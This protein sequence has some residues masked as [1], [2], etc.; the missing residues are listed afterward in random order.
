MMTRSWRRNGLGWR[1]IIPNER[2]N[3]GQWEMSM[4][5]VSLSKVVWRWNHCHIHRQWPSWGLIVMHS[6]ESI[7]GRKKEGRCSFLLGSRS[8]GL[9]GLQNESKRLHVFVL[10]LFDSNIISSG[11]PRW[12][13]FLSMKDILCGIKAFKTRI[14][15]KCM[16]REFWNILKQLKLKKMKRKTTKT[17]I[18]RT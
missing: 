16:E 8:D 4:R 10:C 5:A 15:K 9:G 13:E 18:Q 17:S 7:E 6:Q 12:V 11:I 3:V 14:C 2:R 1:D